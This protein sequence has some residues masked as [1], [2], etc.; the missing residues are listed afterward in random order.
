[1]VRLNFV[2]KGDD[3]IEKG[4]QVSGKGFLGVLCLLVVPLW[5]KKGQQERQ[6]ESLGKKVGRSR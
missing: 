2:K 5:R 6:N 3:A 1:M 4:L